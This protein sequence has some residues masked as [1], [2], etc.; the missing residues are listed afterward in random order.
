VKKVKVYYGLKEFNKGKK[1]VATIGTFDGVHIGHK[2]LLQNLVTHTQKSGGESLLLTFSPHPRMV[3]FPD[4][5]ELKLLNSQKEKI[6]L[7]DELGID[8]LIIEPFTREFSRLTSTEFVRNILVNQIGVSSLVIGYD[9]HF[10]RN[11]EGSFVSLKELSN[12]YKFELKEIGAEV[13][14]DINISSTKIRTALKVGN[15]DTANE[16]LDYKYSIGGEVIEGNK[17][18]R[19]IGFRTA[20]IKIENPHKLI[21]SDGVYAVLV[22]I[23]DSALKGMLNIGRRPTIENS[24]NTTIEVHIF[25]FEQNIYGQHICI[26]FVKRIRNEKKFKN[27]EE[28]ANQLE[29][30]QNKCLSVFG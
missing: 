4:N 17:I 30:D 14:D 29:I 21:P 13:L 25:E 2:K 12:L 7:L 10:G 20:N 15:I 24:E 5:N 27:T 1:I 28:L 18:G 8:H 6:E 22:H 16:Y 3:L 9:H 23:N 11:R 19:T 26:E